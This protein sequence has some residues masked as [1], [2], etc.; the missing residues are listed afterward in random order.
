MAVKPLTVRFGLLGVL[1]VV[2]GTGAAWTVPA[3]KQRVILA[4][5]LLGRGR[6]VSAA[7]LAEALWDESPPPNEPTVLRNYVARLRRVLGPVG[8]RIVGHPPG[9]A[10][11]LRGPEEFDVIEVDRLR[12]AARAEAD[13]GNWKHASTL[14]T[15][16]LTLSGKYLPSLVPGPSRGS[17]RPR[18][19]TSRAADQS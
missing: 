15:T 7:S 1:E 6:T 17:C 11:E 18:C 12:L 3:A 8:P 4:A 19:G 5:L 14:L 2:D 16:A 9:W 10:V 13:A